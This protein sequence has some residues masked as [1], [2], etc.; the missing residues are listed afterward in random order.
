MTSEVTT[1][2]HSPHPLNPEADTATLRCWRTIFEAYAT[3][4]KLAYKDKDERAAVVVSALG[5]DTVNLYY[6]IPFTKDDEKAGVMKTK[7][8]TLLGIVTSSMSATSS[9][10]NNKV[11]RNCPRTA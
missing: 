9:S 5:M 6:S 7:G 4:T 8:N 2:R 1:V 11:T 10:A 3:I